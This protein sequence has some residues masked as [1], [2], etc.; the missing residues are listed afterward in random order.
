[1]QVAEQFNRRRLFSCKLRSW[2]F[3]CHPKLVASGERF[4]SMVEKSSYWQ[5][6]SGCVVGIV[7]SYNPLNVLNWDD[8]YCD[9]QQAASFTGNPS[10]GCRLILAHLGTLNSWNSIGY[11]TTWPHLNWALFT[12]PEVAQ[13][14]TDVLRRMLAEDSAWSG[15][16]LASETSGSFNAWHLR[17]WIPVVGASIVTCLQSGKR[18]WICCWSPNNPQQIRFPMFYSN[19]G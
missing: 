4:V 6:S 11:L 15:R 2:G 14:S 1:M 18:H 9:L 12:W 7:P 13:I 17:A 8:A 3:R 19:L 16:Y 5:L 10:L